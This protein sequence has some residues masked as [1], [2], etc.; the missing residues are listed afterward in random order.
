MLLRSSVGGAL[1]NVSCKSGAR[2]PAL[3]GGLFRAGR[4]GGSCKVGVL[5]SLCEK[6]SEAALLKGSV[7]T[8]G[9]ELCRGGGGLEAAFEG[10]GGG[11]GLRK[12][13]GLV[14]YVKSSDGARDELV[15]ESESNGLDDCREGS[16]GVGALS[17]SSS[18]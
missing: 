3:G 6:D 1:C 14:E 5:D 13:S 10:E 4:G 15:D 12:A 7:S 17:L 16:R 18:K 11:G 9:R 8:D 2:D